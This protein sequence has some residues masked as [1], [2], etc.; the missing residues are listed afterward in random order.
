MP[1]KQA[2]SHHMTLKINPVFNWYDSW[3]LYVKGKIKDMKTITNNKF[4][5]I[6]IAT[7]FLVLSTNLV[8]SQNHFSV[9]ETSGF[10]SD[11]STWSGGVAA[12]TNTTDNNLNLQIAG[13]VVRSGNLSFTGIGARITVQS[14]DTL[15]VD[16][17]LTFANN[18]GI[19]V[20]SNA[21]LVVLGDL[22][23][24]TNFNGSVNGD[25]VVTGEVTVGNSGNIN[26]NGSVYFYD[27]SPDTG[28]SN[29]NGGFDSRTDLEN[30]NNSL[31]SFVEN[32]GTLP[33]E[34][35]SFVVFPQNQQVKLSWAT[36]SEINNDKFEIQRTL[37][38]K[39]FLTIGEINGNGTTNIRQHYNFVDNHPANG[40]AYYRLKQID[41]DG[42]FDYSTLES[43]EMALSNALFRAGPTIAQQ[44]NIRIMANNIGEGTGKITVF[45]LSGATVYT[46]N[47]LIQNSNNS[48]ELIGT[49]NLRN[50]IYLVTLELGLNVYKRKV[51]IDNSN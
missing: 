32:A 46:S 25:V 1:H 45:D 34:L 41:F 5:R 50:G 15:V 47:Q 17:N 35:I 21:I 22:I 19:T 8:F 26:N 23:A 6:Q 48:I 49:Q 42:Q 31:Y 3:Q 27:S 20:E 43:V 16:G 51:I 10:W 7:I 39:S 14:G 13:Y 30:N 37:D 36:A 24:G 18:G 38:G 28:N 44:E 40:I 9:E 12:P 33:V 11:G 2:L 4:F 29:L